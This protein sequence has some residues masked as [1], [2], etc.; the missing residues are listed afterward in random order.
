MSWTEQQGR[1]VFDIDK[2]EQCITNAVKPPRLLLLCNP[3]NPNGR[4]LTR[5]ELTTVDELCQKH[6][7]TIC[8]DEIHCDL[9]LDQTIQ[10]IPYAS[11]SDYAEKHSITLMSASKTFN[12]AGFCCAYAI[13]PNPA[14]REQFNRAKEGII[15]PPDAL[16][17]VVTKAAFQHGSDWHASVVNYLKSNYDYLLK[18]INAIEGLSM[19]PMEATYLAWINVRALNLTDPA[20]FFLDAG[21]ALIAGAQFGNADYVRLNFACPRARLETAIQKIKQ[22]VINHAQRG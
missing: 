14:L 4:A 1:A 3:H 16:G 12:T 19:Q 13:I 20:Q 18:E 15:P 2:L 21:V 8:S 17:Y 7:L 9:I 10:H 11:I 22:A 5:E 6:H